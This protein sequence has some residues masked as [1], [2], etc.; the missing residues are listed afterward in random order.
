VREQVGDP[1][2]SAALLAIGKYLSRG[3]VVSE[4]PSACGPDEPARVVVEVDDQL[5]HH[6]A[7]AEGDDPGGTLEA[8]I[9]TK[10]STRR[11]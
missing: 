9:E 5:T 10:P 2:E 11:R 3:I 1:D 4:P 8:G 6:H 7:V